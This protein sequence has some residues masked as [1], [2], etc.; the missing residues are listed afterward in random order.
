[1]TDAYYPPNAGIGSPPQNFSQEL[2][3]DQVDDATIEI[4]SDT[5][6]VKNG[7]LA[8]AKFKNGDKVSRLLPIG[9]V[10]GPTGLVTTATLAAGVWA[11]VVSSN[12]HA[13]GGE[14]ADGA[15][16]TSVGTIQ[17]A[18][19]DNYI[20]A[21]DVVVR[22]TTK[23]KSVTGTGVAD[24]GSDIDLSVYEQSKVLGTVG[25]DICA[26]AAQ[27]YAAL[28]TVYQKDFVI[29]A[30]NLVAGDLLNLL[31]TARAIENDGGNGSL[32]NLLYSVEVL[33]DVYGA[34]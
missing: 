6:Q 21:G 13:L 7:G 14:L 22:L 26:T 8:F 28:D 9:Q 29:T 15:T 23:L 5:I 19:P 3:A 31:I 18:L 25:A 17:I 30:T 34:A 4:S 32:Q 20:A 2:S 24:N 27:V 11:E 10:R 33:C 1:M 12:V 16:K